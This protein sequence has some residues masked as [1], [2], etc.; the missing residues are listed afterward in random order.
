MG[1]VI[2]T[3]SVDFMPLP[4]TGERWHDH[5]TTSPVTTT[6]TAT[7]AITTTATAATTTTAATAHCSGYPLHDVHLVRLCI[8]H[9]RRIH[10]DAKLRGHGVEV[11]NE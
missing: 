2:A 3:R 8:L 11:I 7:T 5:S 9:W 10:W 4:L 6:T 1:Q